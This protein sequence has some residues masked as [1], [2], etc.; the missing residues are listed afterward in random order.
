MSLFGVG[1]KGTN[2]FERNSSPLYIIRRLEDG[3]YYG[4]MSQK[5]MNPL[6]SLRGLTEWVKRVPKK[7]RTKQK[8]FGALGIFLFHSI[9]S[10]LFGPKGLV[11]W[12]YCLLVSCS[13]PC[14]W[15]LVTIQRFP[16]TSRY[17]LSE[18]SYQLFT[19]SQVRSANFSEDNPFFDGSEIRQ[20]HQLRL[21]AEIP[22]FTTGLGYIP[23]G[24]VWDFWTINSTAQMTV[25]F[26]D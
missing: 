20:T 2:V 19:T 6:C 1:C 21:V 7:H 8:V 23:G 5:L 24:W 12:G 11:G 17:V 18:P 3:P 15:C 25:C 26:L 9:M 22:F 13:E 14:A 16:G 10:S 4:F